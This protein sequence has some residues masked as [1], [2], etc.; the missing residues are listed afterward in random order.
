MSDIKV[1]GYGPD[2][3]TCAIQIGECP[4]HHCEVCG[5][6]ITDKEQRT[7]ARTLTGRMHKR[8]YKRMK[9]IGRRAE[10]PQE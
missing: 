8:C 10:R 1:G 7:A 2:G 5:E 4:V 9:S 6:K 3:C